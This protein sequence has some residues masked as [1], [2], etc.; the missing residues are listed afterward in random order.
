M[1]VAVAGAARAL[2]PILQRVG[3]ILLP[4]LGVK[5]AIDLFE[6]AI[7]GS[8]EAIGGL[9]NGGISSRFAVVDL[10]TNTIIKQ[11]SA[12]KALLLTARRRR[13]CT[14]KEK[15]KIVSTSGAPCITDVT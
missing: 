2:T 9:A 8:D 3:R 5:E 13:P 1:T 10:K 4:L 7:G 14:R 15:I 12:R 11:I 6:Q